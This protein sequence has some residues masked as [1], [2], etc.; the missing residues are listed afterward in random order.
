[1][2]L[3]L[4]TKPTSEGRREDAQDGQNQS[5]TT[6][7]LWPG[8]PVVQ[9]ERIKPD[10]QNI[11]VPLQQGMLEP[12]IK[13]PYNQRWHQKSQVTDK[14]KTAWERRKES[15]FRQGMDN[16]FQQVFLILENQVIFVMSSN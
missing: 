3:Y 4:R 7:N 2:K 13:R 1:M 10:D 15:R 6:G 9:L 16:T 8:R 12:R 14:S 11:Q 5:G